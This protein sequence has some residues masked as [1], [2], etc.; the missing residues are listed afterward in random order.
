[1][2]Y[3]QV[4]PKERKGIKSSQHS[5]ETSSGT[6]VT[7]SDHRVKQ[8]GRVQEKSRGFREMIPEQRLHLAYKERNSSFPLPRM[9]SGRKTPYRSAASKG[10]EK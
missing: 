2:L 7:K 4:L 8:N 10:G 6:G 9:V 3:L 5:T 1:M